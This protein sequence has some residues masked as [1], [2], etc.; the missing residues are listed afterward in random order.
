LNRV[1]ANREA[2]PTFDR[3]RSEDPPTRWNGVARR[4]VVVVGGGVVGC[5]LAFDLSCAGHD[6]V[7]L[8]RDDPPANASRKNAGNVNP[9]LGS[10]PNCVP[11]AL[12]A[13]RL[14]SEVREALSRLGCVELVTAPVER[15]L[16]GF[17]EAERP[18]LE[19]VARLHHATEGFSAHWIGRAEALRREP[20]LAADVA[21]ALVTTGALSVDGAAFVAALAQGAAKLGAAILRAD[22]CGAEVLGDRVV[23][24]RTADRAVPCDELVLATGP[25]VG[26]WRDWLGVEIPVRAVKG[27]MLL[28][29]LPGGPPCCDL[30]YGST[31]LYRRRD[32][33]VWVGTTSAESG[34]DCVPTADARRIL[35][36][37]ATQ[38]IP[39][40]GRAEILAHVAALRPIATP[41]API[42]RRAIG[43]RNVLIAN[44]GGFKGVLWSVAIARSIRNLIGART[45]AISARGSEGN[46]E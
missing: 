25:W 10:S 15:L 34:L 19:E 4:R 27:E 1:N 30:T 21:F 39:A 45:T 42:A 22:A 37:G 31:S 41:D 32:A 12:A 26:E 28:I 23:A 6:V 2:R 8:D 17:D 20:R 5:A 11:Q 35:T 16:L 9:L 38:M 13:F 14:H 46:K 3:W 40:A 18:R 36:R 43:W 24:V 7:L 44:G 33:Q 29:D